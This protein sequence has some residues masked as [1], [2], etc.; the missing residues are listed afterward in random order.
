M[1]I[2]VAALASL[3]LAHGAYAAEN[4]LLEDTNK[5]LAAGNPA[6]VLMHLEKLIGRGNIVAAQRLGLMYRDGKGVPQ[7]YGKA[8]KLLKIASEPD[9]IRIWYKRGVPD[10]QY[11]LAVMFRDGIGGKADASR[12]E[13]WF[14]EAAEQGRPQAQLALAR[15]YF[16]GE[17]IKRDPERAFFWSSIAAA[18]LT[19][20]A[21]KEAV[22]IRDEAQ[23]QLAPT[24]LAGAG[25]LISSWKPRT[26]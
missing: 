11:A 13:F 3:A 16:K 15:M 25:K 7:D 18:S 1:R 23:K 12:A 4:V 6:A 10:A 14:N 19:E 21:Q 2:V 20:P 5:A 17:G 9:L 8:R 26:E 22:A 24:Q